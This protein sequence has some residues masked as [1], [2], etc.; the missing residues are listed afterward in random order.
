MIL[1]VC[2]NTAMDKILFIEAWTPGIP[3]RTD[4]IIHSVG[5]KGLNSAI[6]L[7]QLGV[8]TVGLG[9]F[10]GD[11]GRELAD[12]VDAYGVQV[13]PVWVDGSNRISH[14]I[15]E[16][17]TRQQNHVIGG[18][19]IV[20]PAQAEELIWRYESH[21]QKADWVVLAGTLPHSLPDDFYVPLIIAAQKKG[22]PVLID[23]QKAFMRKAIQVK[24]TV[25]KMNREEFGWTFDL[26]YEPLADLVSNVQD[27]KAKYD[28]KDVV[29]TMGKDGIV[30]VTSDGIFHARA[31]EQAVVNAAGAGDA[32][33]A[34]LA[35]RLSQGD[36]WEGALRRA[37]AV[38]ASSVT[39]ERTGDI[40]V[41]LTGELEKMTEVKRLA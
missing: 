21:L 36:S 4:R 26:P 33:S 2:P 12:L 25:T 15:A 40:D 22:V 28:L 10:A 16:K 6:V 37:A 24:P 17:N 19:P 31:P 5:G 23:A 14:V 1:T 41:T 32:V 27:M 13:D 8:E 7:G 39:T 30:S 29:I 3:M 11:I 34:V 18:N 20:S 35:W 38:S 9:F